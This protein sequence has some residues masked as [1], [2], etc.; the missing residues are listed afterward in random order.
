VIGG[1]A[2]GLAGAFALTGLLK[3]MLFRVG[4][5][6]PLT[7]VVVTAILTAIALTA[8]YLPARKAARLDPVEALRAD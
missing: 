1:A 8:A 6:D 4:P 7:F 3:S 2:I 5:R